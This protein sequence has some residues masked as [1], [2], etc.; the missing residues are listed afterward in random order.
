M[1]FYTYVLYRKKTKLII[2]HQQSINIK[3]KEITVYEKYA[4]T[5]IPYEAASP[6]D[7]EEHSFEQTSVGTEVRDEKTVE[8]KPTETKQGQY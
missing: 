1:Y 2:D 7:D 8:S 3:P 5:D 4:Q 6:D